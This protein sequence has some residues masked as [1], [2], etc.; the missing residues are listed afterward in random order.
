MREKTCRLRFFS[1][2]S[3]DCLQEEPMENANRVAVF[4]CALALLLQAT[5]ARAQSALVDQ[6]RPT[7]IQ[8]SKW[9]EVVNGIRLLKGFTGGDVVGDFSGQVFVREMSADGK[10]TRLEAEYAVEGERS[11]TAMMR[12]GAD[13]LTGAAILDGTILAGWRKGARIHAEFITIA[14]PSPAEPACPGHP[15]GLNCNLGT[16][17]VGRVP[18]N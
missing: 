15:P 14:A 9:A 16:I 11:F 13:A 8:Y 1:N 18:G 12:G 2:G 10:L 4:V 17:W 6:A 3:T 5:V 7:V